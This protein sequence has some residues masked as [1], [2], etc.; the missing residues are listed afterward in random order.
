M[1]KISP[2]KWLT[3][4]YKEFKLKEKAK[5]FKTCSKCGETKL[6]SRF[7]ADRRN[8]DG[9]KGIC[10]TCVNKYYKR[11]YDRNRE[12]FKAL[13]KK[14]REDHKES[15]KEYHQK[16]REDHREYL[17]ETARKWYLE[18]KETIKERNLKYYHENREACQAVRELWREKNREKIKKYNREYKRKQTALNK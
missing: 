6:I 2:P 12:K 5:C 15:R 17:K 4:Y 9:Y 11:R 16:Y 13:N 7:S 10:K 3:D 18:N 8:S 14:Y 1:N